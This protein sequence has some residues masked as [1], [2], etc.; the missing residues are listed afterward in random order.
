[1]IG[2]ILQKWQKDYG[3]YCLVSEL[4]YSE[5]I[6][7]LSSGDFDIALIKLSGD[8]SGA[9][10]YLDAFSASSSRNYSG[11]DSKKYENIIS[12]AASASDVQRAAAYC[13]EAEQFILDNCCFTPLFF[14]K[15]YVFRQNG[16]SRIGYDPFGGAVL[17]RE[18]LRTED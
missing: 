4:P 5:Y 15:E 16:V 13:L 7:A 11:F 18:A 10:S 3:F 9:L 12:E 17:Y 1:M 2:G 8:G 14:G 6:S